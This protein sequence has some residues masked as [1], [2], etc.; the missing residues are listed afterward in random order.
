MRVCLSLGTPSVCSAFWEMPNGY[1]VIVFGSSM[2]P[3]SL[4]IRRRI[5]EQTLGVP[6]RS[7]A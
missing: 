1:I 2:C 3:Y 4:R 5:A 6:G 7:N